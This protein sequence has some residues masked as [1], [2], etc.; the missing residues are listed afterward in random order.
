M[1]NT[2]TGAKV[3]THL[4]S[5]SVGRSAGWLADWVHE[6]GYLARTKLTPARTT[7]RDDLL[8]NKVTSSI[9]NE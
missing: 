6:H 5:Q 7:P 2:L 3:I 4:V 1:E 9:A 8:C